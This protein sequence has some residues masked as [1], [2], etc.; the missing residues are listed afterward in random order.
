MHSPEGYLRLYCQP[1]DNLWEAKNILSQKLTA[2]AE[3]FTAKVDF[4]AG[5]AGDRAGIVIHGRDLATLSF[6]ALEDGS[7]VLRQSECYKAEKGAE[8]V[9]NEECLWSED[10]QLLLRVSISEG[11]MCFFSWAEYG[12][13]FHTIGKPFKAKEGK[14]IGAK[15][16]LFA[17]TSGKTNDG[18]WIDVDWV[19]VTK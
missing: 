8:E 12:G 18:G 14:W 2:P 15:F 16:G 17:V 6:V 3:T 4:R 13:E 11:G 9:V 7:I 5:V 1:Y 10:R 19:R